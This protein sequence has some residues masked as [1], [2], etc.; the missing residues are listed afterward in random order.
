MRHS[1]SSMRGLSITMLVYGLSGC[2]S[3]VP[4]VANCPKLPELPPAL[5]QPPEAANALSE[6]EQALLELVSAANG[7]PQD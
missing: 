3:Q 6:L 7:T 5:M 2:A 4:I 1:K